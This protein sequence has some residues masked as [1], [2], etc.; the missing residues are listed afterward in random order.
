MECPFDYRRV[1][2]KPQE[3]KRFTKQQVSGKDIENFCSGEM[4]MKN[5]YCKTIYDNHMRFLEH[6]I[7]C[8]QCPLYLFKLH[9][10]GE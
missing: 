7:I 2:D 6:E 5:Y 10:G 4:F 1:S 9:I 3:D 8:E